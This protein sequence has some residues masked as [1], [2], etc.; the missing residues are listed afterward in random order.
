MTQ[1]K[2]LQLHDIDTKV[3]V[4]SGDDTS[5][6]ENSSE[7]SSSDETS[8][9]DSSSDESSEDSSNED[10]SSEEESDVDCKK[11][12]KEDESSDEELDTDSK[13]IEQETWTITFSEAVENHNSMQVIGTK[14]KEGATVSELKD[15]YKT[16]TKKGCKCQLIDL[17]PISPSKIRKNAKYGAQLLIVRGGIKLLAKDYNALIKEVK[18]S[19]KIVDKKAWMR[20]RVVNKLARHNLCYADKAQK[21]DYENKKGTIVAF[22]T[23]PELNY[24]RS[25][26]GEMFGSKKYKNLFAELNY[27]YDIKKCGI[28]P[29]G[30]G[31]RRIVIGLRF[32]ASMN[33]H[34]QWYYKSEPIGKRVILKL[35]EGDFYIM[36]DK[37]TGNDWKRKIIPTL[38]HAAGCKKYTPESTKGS[39]YY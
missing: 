4:D 32:G 29:H 28:S 36:S 3:L 30:D 34:Y 37:A 22:K 26:I 13:K 1:K 33:L 25:S 6:E 15:I 14:A 8:S 35:N 12:K 38:R 7:D 2:K 39:I 18:S 23:V 27:Y 21:A 20:G 19:K 9:E 16:F 5:S 11:M 24:V 17:D 10:S 31:E